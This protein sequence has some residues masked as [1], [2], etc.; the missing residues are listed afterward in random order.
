MADGFAAEVASHASTRSRVARLVSARGNMYSS[1]VVAIWVPMSS[2]IV[3]A[4]A[5]Y[6]SRYGASTSSCSEQSK[7]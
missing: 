6:W 5:R 4:T 3:S 1:I 2:Q 7:T